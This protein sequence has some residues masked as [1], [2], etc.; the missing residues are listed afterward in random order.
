MHLRTPHLSMPLR[1][2]VGGTVI[3]MY[4]LGAIYAIFPRTEIGKLGEEYFFVSGGISLLAFLICCILHF[5]E[6]VVRS[7]HHWKKVRHEPGQRFLLGDDS[8]V[9]FSGWVEFTTAILLSFVVCGF[10]I[11]ILA[12]VAYVVSFGNLGFIPQFRGMS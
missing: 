9:I 1:L 2:I 7:V 4:L 6:K 5:S 3:G 10:W 8:V 11:A 12:I